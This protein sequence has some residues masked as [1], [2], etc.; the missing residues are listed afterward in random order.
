M[1]RAIRTASLALALTLALAGPSLATGTGDTSR[2]QSGPQVCQMVPVGTDEWVAGNIT[3]RRVCQTI[4]QAPGVPA[5]SVP[6]SVARLPRRTTPPA[7]LWLVWHGADCPHDLR[8]PL[9][10]VARRQD[11]VLARCPAAHAAARHKHRWRLA[12]ADAH[13]RPG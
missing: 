4:T 3:H 12:A 11:R 7:P 13:G 6:A 10:L 5:V 8:Q 9:A 2:V 1:I